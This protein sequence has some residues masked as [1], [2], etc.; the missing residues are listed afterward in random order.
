[1]LLACL[2]IQKISLA[3]L[4]T[5][6]QPDR[7]GDP[8]TAESDTES[9]KYLYLNKHIQKDM[10]DCNYYLFNKVKRSKRILKGVQIF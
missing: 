10:S 6:F 2:V 7:N 1:M 3:T 9:V 5:G 8:D 4:I